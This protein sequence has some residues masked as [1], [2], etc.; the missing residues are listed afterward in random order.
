MG[1]ITRHSAALVAVA[2]TLGTLTHELAGLGVGGSGAIDGIEAV[3]TAVAIVATVVHA[4]VQSAAGS[5]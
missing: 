4:Y 2:A 5:K 1:W 3:G